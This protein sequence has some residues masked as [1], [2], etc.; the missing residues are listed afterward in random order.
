[1]CRC[2]SRTVPDRNRLSGANVTCYDTRQVHNHLGHKMA[3]PK[4][5]ANAAE[6]QAAYRARHGST[7]SVQ[8]PDDVKAAL[9]AHLA[10]Q[11]RDGDADATLASVIEK[12]LRNQFLRKR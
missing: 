7:V 9:D 4:L 2:D 1:M 12:I 6:R 3:R 8:L 5:Y 10:K 11:H